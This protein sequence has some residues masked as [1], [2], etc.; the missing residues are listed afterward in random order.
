MISHSHSVRLSLSE[1][2]L[3]PIEDGLVMGARSPIGHVAMSRALSLLSTTPYRR[4]PVEDDVVSD[5]LVREAILRK[6]D[7]QEL[8]SLVLRHVKPF[9]AADEILHL[10]LEVTTHLDIQAL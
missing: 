8:V 5:I 3:P 1:F 6:L 2:L 4:V 9:M 7:E 10:K